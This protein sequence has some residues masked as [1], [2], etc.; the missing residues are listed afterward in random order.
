MKRGGILAAAAIVIIGGAAAFFFWPARLPAV[1]ASPAQP[2]GPALVARGEYLAK[3][4]DCVACHTAP[5]GRPFAGGRGF[6]LPFGTIYAPNITPDRETGLG[7]WSDAEFVRAIRA[8]VGRHGEEL[9]PALPYTSYSLM[10]D[11]DAL[12]I[13]AYLASLAPIRAEAPENTLVFPFDQRP[14]MRGWKLLFASDRRFTPDATRSAEWNRGAYLARSLAHCG[15]CHTPRNLLMATKSG[16]EFAG[17]VVDGWKAYNIT[18]D[19]VAGVGSWSEDA[20]RRYLATGNAEG[21]GGASGSMAE[22]VDLSFRHLDAADIAAIV[23]YLRSVPPRL[24]SMTGP[25][26]PAPAA[27]EA[28]SAWSPP[29]AEDRTLG[30]NV[31]AGACASCHSWDGSGQQLPNASLRGARSVNDPDGVNALRTILEGVKLRTAIGDAVMPA[32]GG[33]LTDA[34]VAAVTNYVIAHFGGKAGRVAAADVKAAR[35]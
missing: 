28:S 8:G 32:F 1:S 35:R 30:S 19:P 12:A 16:S 25:I 7:D 31:F 18:P 26:D 5:G 17:A 33:I 13:R 21:H 23:T 34:E 14:L 10:S 6:T 22:A 9:Y 20:L 11:D 2:V 3:A 15:E 4:A 29:A 24:D 27:V